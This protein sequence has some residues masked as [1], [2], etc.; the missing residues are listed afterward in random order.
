M[1]P[2]RI[3][4]CGRRVRS[5]GLCFGH[6]RTDGAGEVSPRRSALARDDLGRKHCRTC[7]QWLPL[8]S[9]TKDFRGKDGLRSICLACHSA[10]RRVMKYGVTPEWFDLTFESQGRRCAICRSAEPRGR[11]WAI[12]HD[13]HC[14]PDKAASC[15]S[16]VRGILCSPCNLALGL[17]GD[18]ADVL[19]AAANYLRSRMSEAHASSRL[20]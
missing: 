18:E 6:N 16:C 13:H 19:N 2:C 8:E 17:M 1:K 12:D 3:E 15:G 5:Q 14:C 11:G 20:K 7:D 9:F 4:G 10:K